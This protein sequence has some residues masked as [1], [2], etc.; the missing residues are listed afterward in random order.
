MF[1]AIYCV[2]CLFAMS[3]AASADNDIGDVRNDIEARGGKV[4]Y[5][6]HFDHVEY[7]KAVGSVP[8]GLSGAYASNLAKEIAI[9]TGVKVSSEVLNQMLNGSTYK[10][11][12]GQMQAGLATYRHW[13]VKSLHVP[14]ATS[15]GVRMQLVSSKIYLPNTHELYIRLIK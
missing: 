9:K 10:F 8:T 12:S 14:R 4:L 7:L 1:R 5:I 11:G 2:V 6:K 15:K 13:E 3:S